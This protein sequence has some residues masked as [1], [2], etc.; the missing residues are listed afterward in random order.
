MDVAVLAGGISVEHE[1]SLQTGANMLALLRD[2]GHRAWPVFVDRGN[3]WRFGRADSAL[4]DLARDPAPGLALDEALRRL[5]ASGAV[6]CLGLHGAFG[7][8]GQLQRR[9]EALGV[10]FTGAGSHASA[11]GMDKEL[12]KLAATRVG[13]R[14]AAHE[15]V[16]PGRVPQAR[17]LQ[18]VGLPCFVKPVRGGSSVGVA[19]VTD[20]GQLEAAVRAAQVE[21]GRGEALVE[22][23]VAGLELACAVLRD[24]AELRCLP[25]VAIVPAGGA[26]YDYHAKYVA[27]D[28]RLLC[29]ADVPEATRAEVERVAAALHAGLQLRGVA[30]VDFIV[31]EADAAAVFIEVNTLPGFTGHSLVPLA[32]RVA[33]L[34]PLHVL[35]CALAEAL[36]AVPARAERGAP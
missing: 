8:D 24:G 18:T 21:D 1:V 19:R 23:A 34:S 35:E 31:R 32:A 27:E 7:E 14:T 4:E 25:L 15:R 20:A 9:L 10:P 2:G 5:A 6:A 28:T 17:L 3:R 33:G 29:P 22:A 16:G 11:I 13:A 36:A 26:F 30:R 12:S